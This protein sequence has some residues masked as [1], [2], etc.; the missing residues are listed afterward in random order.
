M[1]YVREELRQD[2]DAEISNLVDV[3]QRHQDRDMPGL[4]NYAITQIV[5]SSL[6]PRLGWNYNSLLQV[7]GTLECSK[8]EIYARLVRPYEDSK[9]EQN[10]DLEHFESL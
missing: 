6:Q 8:Q 1:P 9:I 3:I 10:G 5:L 4:V 2:V 7:I